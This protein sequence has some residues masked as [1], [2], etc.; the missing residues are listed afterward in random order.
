MNYAIYEPTMTLP[1]CQ[2]L[3]FPQD[4]RLTGNVQGESLGAAFLDAQAQ[5][6]R[7]EPGTV[8]EELSGDETRHRCIQ[9]H[10]ELLPKDTDRIA[11]IHPLQWEPC[12]QNGHTLKK[13]KELS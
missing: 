11:R 6:L 9:V 3:Q 2:Q 13:R 12:P 1:D 4:Y 8:L 7:V 5:G 10:W